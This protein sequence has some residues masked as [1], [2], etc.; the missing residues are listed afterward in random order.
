MLTRRDL[1]AGLLSAWQY[2]CLAGLFALAVVARL[3]LLIPDALGPQRLLLTFARRFQACKVL[4]RRRRL[5]CFG[6]LPERVVAAV[7]AQAERRERQRAW[8]LLQQLAVV[9]DHHQPAGP[10]SQL[11]QQAFTH[12]VAPH[13]T[14][15]SV[16]K[17]FGEF[18]KERRAV[19]QQQRDAL[20]RNHSVRHAIILN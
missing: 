3:A 4:R 11:R 17:L 20:Q 10:L 13:Q 1:T 8:H 12:A 9:A 16:V 14:D 6:L 7:A 15:M 18:G 19:G 2:L 5:L